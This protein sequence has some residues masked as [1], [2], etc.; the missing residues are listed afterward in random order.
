MS[1]RLAASRRKVQDAAD[2]WLD[3]FQEA[4]I[5]AFAAKYGEGELP[6]DQFKKIAEDA[7]IIADLGLDAYQERWPGL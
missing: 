6:Q 4:I 1:S 5:Y 7:S 2:L 3:L